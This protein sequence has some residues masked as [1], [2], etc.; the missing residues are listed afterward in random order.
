LCVYFFF[1]ERN[2]CWLSTL[3]ASS[4]HPTHKKLMGWSKWALCQGGKF[5]EV[6]FPRVQVSPPHTHTHTVTKHS[7]GYCTILLS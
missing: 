2:L 1:L 3:L 6:F 7:K 5:P 4:P